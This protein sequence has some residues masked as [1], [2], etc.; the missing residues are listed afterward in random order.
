V[1]GLLTFA[2]VL[3]AIERSHVNLPI[4]SEQN[5]QVAVKATNE[6]LGWLAFC[7]VVTAALFYVYTVWRSRDA[8]VVGLR[9]LRD[10]NRRLGPMWDRLSPGL[11]AQNATAVCA[12]N[13]I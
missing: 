4:F 8:D 3:I 10:F 11:D 5:D 13:L 6:V 1:L 2:A 9:K 12:E 7:V